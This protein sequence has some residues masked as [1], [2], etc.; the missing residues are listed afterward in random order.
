MESQ[1]EGVTKVGKAGKT[2]K[3]VHAC[4][5]HQHTGR[6]GVLMDGVAPEQEKAEHVR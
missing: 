6:E 3:K 2:G 1:E 4:A 5:W